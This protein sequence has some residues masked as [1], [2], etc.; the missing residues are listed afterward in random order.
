MNINKIKKFVV[1]NV[2]GTVK[3]V[4]DTVSL[5]KEE[6][7]PEVKDIGQTEFNGNTIYL[8]KYDLLFSMSGQKNIPTAICLFMYDQY[9]ILVNS[10]WEN[11][12]LDVQEAILAHEIGHIECGHFKKIAEMSILDRLLLP[13]KRAYGDGFSIDMEREADEWG[14]K[15]LGT[16]KG[17]IQM[18][19]NFLEHIQ[20][21][22][23]ND[24]EI[25]ARIWSIQGA[26]L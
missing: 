9:I 3:G 10:A 1:S 19:D 15:H 8:K 13:I 21:L 18:L 2:K 17:Y 6:G 4:I 24:A 14:V 7:R 25:Y 16:N 20:F 23:A 26:I 5:L 22:G 12:P 11:A